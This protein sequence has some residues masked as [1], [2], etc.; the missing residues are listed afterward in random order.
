MCVCVCVAGG[1]G[2]GG[3]GRVGFFRQAWT[4]CV[5][6]RGETPKLCKCVCKGERDLSGVS[7]CDGEG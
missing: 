1:G 3:G 7:I 2:G 4:T 5:K 6:E